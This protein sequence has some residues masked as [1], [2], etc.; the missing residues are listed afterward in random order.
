MTY[1]LSVV[2]ALVHRPLPQHVSSGE[3]FH[4]GRFSALIF[5]TDADFQLFHGVQN[6]GVVFG[7]GVKLGDDR[8]SFS[9]STG[10]KEM[11]R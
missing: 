3:T 8:S 10:P 9:F 6:N 4:P 2:P 11:P 5:R 1:G 7:N